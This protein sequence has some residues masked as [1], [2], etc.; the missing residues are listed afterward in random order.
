MQPM[1]DTN[2]LVAPATASALAHMAA[3]ATGPLPGTRDQVRA[4]TH[5]VLPGHQHFL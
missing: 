5:R 1:L 2:A 4:R 3:S